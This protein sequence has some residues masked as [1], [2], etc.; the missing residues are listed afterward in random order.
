MS[1]RPD[2]EREDQGGQHGA[3]DDRG[4]TQGIGPQHVGSVV[5]RAVE[6]GG[7]A[8]RHR[9]VLIDACPHRAGERGRVH[10]VAGRLGVGVAPDVGLLGQRRDFVG[11]CQPAES[12]Y[13]G[14]FRTGGVGHLGA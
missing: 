6:I 2:R 11:G 8:L 7:Q 10:A 5:Q 1:E 12:I 9:A 3:E 4:V 14:C 13:G